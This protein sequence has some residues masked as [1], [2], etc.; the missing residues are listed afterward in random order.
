M[1]ISSGLTLN[2][3]IAGVTS[4]E[5]GDT[6]DIRLPIMGAKTKHKDSYDN[7]YK[8]KFLIKS[9]RHFFNIT[10]KIHTTYMIVVKDSSNQEFSAE[11]I[12]PTNEKKDGILYEVESA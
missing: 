11:G 6:V 8:G 1:Q 9:L 12:P 10:D 4:M 2:C 7:V 5:A 3:E